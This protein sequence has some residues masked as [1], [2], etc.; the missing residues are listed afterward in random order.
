MAQGSLETP[1]P[2]M[3][4][5]EDLKK[6][7]EELRDFKRRKTRPPKAKR[8]ELRAEREQ[9]ANEAVEKDRQVR[10]SIATAEVSDVEAELPGPGV[11]E[12]SDFM[13]ECRKLLSDHS[14]L[15]HEIR[16]KM[17]R[18][19]DSSPLAPPAPAAVEAIVPYQS[20][21]CSTQKIEISPL[22]IRFTHAKILCYYKT[23]PPNKPRTIL[24]SAQEMV[25]TRT[26][27]IAGLNI[28]VV[29]HNGSFYTA[30]TFNR[31]LCLHRLLAIYFPE[32]FSKIQVTVVD[33]S[34]R[35]DFFKRLSTPCSGD[36]VRVMDEN[37]KEL[38]IVGKEEGQV[39]WQEARNVMAGLR[40][41]H[42]Q[43]PPVPLAVFPQQDVTA[44]EWSWM[45]AAAVPVPATYQWPPA[46]PEGAAGYT[47]YE[48]ME[49]RPEWPYAWE[50]QQGGQQWPPGD[51]S[52]YRNKEET[53]QG[54]SPT[55]VYHTCR[56]RIE[57]ARSEPDDQVGGGS[58]GRSDSS[59]ALFQSSA[60]LPGHSAAPNTALYLNTASS[61][62]KQTRQ[63][64]TEPS[65]SNLELPSPPPTCA[66]ADLST[67]CSEA[68][69]ATDCQPHPLPHPPPSLPRCK[70]CPIL[71]P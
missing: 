56:S 64:Q 49:E 12:L 47:G 52:R 23:A 37:G 4:N 1:N 57:D 18:S 53:A 63:G 31:R 40:Q 38:G 13:K 39:T 41:R 26:G 30:A 24:G 61:L 22:D 36:F 66:W 9:K 68:G 43:P 65:T 17:D 44:S 54:S 51:F 45:P 42:N 32:R 3:D 16:A 8:A 50:G 59:A 35:K 5:Y 7:L 67:G 33:I 2:S 46:T 69:S 28:E 29:W 62:E 10:P 14:R 71:V 34:T 60:S 19:L 48:R 15:L 6:E 70:S 27:A 58:E 25:G 21:V 11:D 55:D 20:K